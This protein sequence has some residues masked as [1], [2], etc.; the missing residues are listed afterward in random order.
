MAYSASPVENW[1]KHN[2]KL[3]IRYS[4]GGIVA[5]LRG[6]QV[7]VALVKYDDK[8][9]YILPKGG[10]EAGETPEFAARRE[11]AEEAGFRQ[12]TLLADLGRL[13]R[14][15]FRRDRWIITQY[16]LY[17]TTELVVVPLEKRYSQHW[18]PLNSLPRLF[19]PEQYQLVIHNQA[20]IARKLVELRLGHSL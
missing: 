4:A 10:I 6:R 8:A 12:L 2:E 11:I 16:Y 15:A 14:L 18:F 7:W 13:E 20:V 9:D 17:T 19:W 1:H 3:P 5:Q